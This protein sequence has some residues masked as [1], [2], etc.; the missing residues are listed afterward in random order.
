M[1][2]KNVVESIMLLYLKLGG[3]KE[4]NL[5]HKSGSENKGVRKNKVPI[6]YLEHLGLLGLEQWGWYCL[7]GDLLF[8]SG[9]YFTYLY[10]AD[11]HNKMNLFI[12][13]LN[14]Y[15][16]IWTVWKKAADIMIIHEFPKNFMKKLQKN[17]S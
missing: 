9:L 1:P 7:M 2:E 17:D 14:I 6:H 8:S 13:L 5:L 15:S 4:R 16:N 3:I 11:R 10:E 12:E